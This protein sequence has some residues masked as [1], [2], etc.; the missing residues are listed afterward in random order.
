MSQAPVCSFIR[1]HSFNVVV[2]PNGKLLCEEQY[3]GEGFPDA[4]C[5][6]YGPYWTLVEHNMQSARDWLGY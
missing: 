6:F 5:E 2:L 1:Q 3:A 4:A